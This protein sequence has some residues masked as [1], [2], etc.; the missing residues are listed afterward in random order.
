MLERSVGVHVEEDTITTVFDTR[1]QNDVDRFHLVQDVAEREGSPL[2]NGRTSIAIIGCGHVGMACAQAIL[3]SQLIRELVLIDESVDRAKGE[4][5]DLQQAVPLG[6]PV[7]ITAGS[8]RDA[9]ASAS[10]ILTVGAPGKFSG[11]RLDMLSGN[12]CQVWFLTGLSFN[13]LF[14]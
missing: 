1:V 7:K 14:F 10:A 5:L 9:A 8:Y 4:A 11:A 3:Q 13:P 6:M 12:V 2:R